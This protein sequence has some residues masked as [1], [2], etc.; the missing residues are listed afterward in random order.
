MFEWHRLNG[1]KSEQTQRDGE[2][3]RSLVCCSPWGRRVGH[4][5]AIEQQRILELKKKDERNKRKRER[6]RA[7]LSRSS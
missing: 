7:L 2:G 3:Q 4:N 1:P 6:K 5:L